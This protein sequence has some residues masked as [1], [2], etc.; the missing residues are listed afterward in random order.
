M[1]REQATAAARMSFGSTAAMLQ[2]R[3]DC[4]AGLLVGTRHARA[5]GRGIQNNG[6]AFGKLGGGWGAAEWI[7]LRRSRMEPSWPSGWTIDLSNMRRSSGTVLLKQ[8]CH[9]CAVKGSR[10]NLAATVGR[11]SGE[12]PSMGQTEFI[13]TCVVIRSPVGWDKAH[14]LSSIWR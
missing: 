5:N 14:P 10:Q 2:R 13:H 6:I 1:E 3:S 4:W 7:R 9:W 12:S 8:Q 11:L